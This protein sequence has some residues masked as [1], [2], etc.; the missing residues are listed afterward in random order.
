[1][2]TEIRQLLKSLLVEA[3]PHLLVLDDIDRADRGTIEMTE[4][5]VRNLIGE[6]GFPLLIVATQEPNPGDNGLHEAFDN[7]STGVTPEYIRLGPLSVGAVE[8]LLLSLV[9]DEPRVHRLATRLQREGEG[10]PFFIGEMI[11]GLIEEGV[12][13]HGE[14]GSRGRIS[15]D[16][17]AIMES[18]LP[19]PKSIRE[20][21]KSIASSREL[22]AVVLLGDAPTFSKYAIA[23]AGKMY[24]S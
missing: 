2:C 17:N 14:D 20:A 13:V 8:E 3:G 11:R 12:I 16:S 22:K 6:A 18:S 5:V 19:V 24:Y 21:I 4:Y 10:V 7:V 9:H 23:R 15:L 1:M